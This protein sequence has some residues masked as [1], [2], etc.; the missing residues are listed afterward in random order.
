MG[1]HPHAPSWLVRSIPS[2]N[3]FNILTNFIILFLIKQLICQNRD[4]NNPTTPFWT[5][6][7]VVRCDKTDIIGVLDTGLLVFRLP[8]I[9]ISTLTPG[10]GAVL[11][12]DL[13][14]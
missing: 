2:G 11:V 10:T 6:T 14:I 12:V 1:F 4:V 3:W 7:N 5:E 13:E 9:T 8:N